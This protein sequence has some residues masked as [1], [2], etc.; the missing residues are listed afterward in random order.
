[1]AV[2]DSA[3]WYPVAAALYSQIRW[4]QERPQAQERRRNEP[5]WLP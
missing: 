5:R 1:M 4:A 3:S 2:K